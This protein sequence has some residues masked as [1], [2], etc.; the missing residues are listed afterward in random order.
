MS[1]VNPN[2]LTVLS[3]VQMASSFSSAW[4][5]LVSNQSFAFQAV[6]TGSPVGNFTLESSCDTVANETVTLPT[7]SDTIAGSSHAAGGAAG[8]FSWYYNQGTVPFNWVRCV[9]T[10]ASGSGLLTSLTFN[11]K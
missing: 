1:T 8:S 4:L 6:W 7:H 9:Y 5:P 11:G 10:A 3:S 2:D